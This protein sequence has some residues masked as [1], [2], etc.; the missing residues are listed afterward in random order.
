MGDPQ[1]ISYD[2]TVNGEIVWGD[3]DEEEE[4]EEEEE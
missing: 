4:E 1:G 3:D 2:G